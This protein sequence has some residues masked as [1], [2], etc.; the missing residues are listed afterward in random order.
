MYARRWQAVLMMLTWSLICVLSVIS[1]FSQEIWQQEAM[2]RVKE[3]SSRA[4]EVHLRGYTNTERTN[5]ADHL[6]VRGAP[7]GYINVC[8]Q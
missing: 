8:D 1:F 4:Y 6:P 7:S 5:F 3:I 2:P